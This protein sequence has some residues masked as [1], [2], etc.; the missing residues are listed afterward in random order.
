MH[1]GGGDYFDVRR[2]NDG[3]WSAVVADVSGKGVSSALLAALLQGAFLLASD[4]GGDIERLM[5]AL[6]TR[7]EPGPGHTLKG[8]HYSKRAS[9]TLP[10]LSAA[11]TMI[12][13]RAT[14]IARCP[15]G[16]FISD[17]PALWKCWTGKAAPT[18]FLVAESSLWAHKHREPSRSD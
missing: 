15:G 8:A 17:S 3:A 11:T 16:T 10:V 6:I 2:L 18:G 14:V 5:L 4:G 9:Q 1:R 13:S 12:L 7:R